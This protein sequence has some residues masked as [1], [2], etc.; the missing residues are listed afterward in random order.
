VGAMDVTM[1]L[2]YAQSSAMRKLG[3]T[4]TRKF[5][6]SLQRDVECFRQLAVQIERYGLSILIPPKPHSFADIEFFLGIVF[7]LFWDCKNSGV[8]PYLQYI[9]SRDELHITMLTSHLHL[10]NELS[11]CFTN[12]ILMA[13][14]V[15]LHLNSKSLVFVH[16]CDFVQ[17]VVSMLRSKR[18]HVVLFAL[19][20]LQVLLGVREKLLKKILKKLRSV[21]LGF[22]LAVSNLLHQY[23]SNGLHDMEIC[24]CETSFGSSQNCAAQCM[25]RLYQVIL[26]LHGLGATT[27][28]PK[29]FGKNLARVVRSRNFE[30]PFMG[31]ELDEVYNKGGYMKNMPRT[32]KAIQRHFHT[33]KLRRCD[34]GNC[35][36]K[37]T[38]EQHFKFCAR[39]RVPRYCS[40]RCQKM[41]WVNEHKLHCFSEERV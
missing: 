4:T 29:S 38:I 15:A 31:K 37:E 36:E 41:H 34:N 27:N 22:G 25:Q 16:N 32:V 14:Y 20:A 7:D 28:F 11:M 40:V 21:E 24:I 5:D 13:R 19:E 39:C 35:L 18:Q 3:D 33:M 12:H 26:V 30:T 8:E 10:C 2:H 1:F 6:M 23:A 9:I 17:E